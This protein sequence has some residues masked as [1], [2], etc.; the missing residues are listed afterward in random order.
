MKEILGNTQNLNKDSI[1]AV[2]SKEHSTECNTNF[3]FLTLLSKLMILLNKF[4]YVNQQI[5]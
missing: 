4:S 2:N 5:N 3:I 1:K